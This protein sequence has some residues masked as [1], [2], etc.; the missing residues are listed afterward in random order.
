MIVDADLLTSNKNLLKLAGFVSKVSAFA[1]P[2]R[3]RI[4]GDIIFRA[5]NLLFTTSRY[6]YAGN[7]YGLRPAP[8]VFPPFPQIKGDLDEIASQ[9]A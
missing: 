6:C 5:R 4:T 9:A 7:G 8:T 3:S 2:T 1:F